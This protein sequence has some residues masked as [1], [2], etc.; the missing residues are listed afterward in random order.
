MPA[1][2]DTDDGGSGHGK[3]L[4][5][6]KPSKHGL[7]G[8]EVRL[9]ISLNPGGRAAAGVGTGAETYCSVSSSPKRPA[10]NG[11]ER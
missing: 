2:V 7:L 3:A 9:T 4:Q 11:E 8:F 6:K 1:Q 10:N 5:K